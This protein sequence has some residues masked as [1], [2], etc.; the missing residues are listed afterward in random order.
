MTLSEERNDRQTQISYIGLNECVR[1][2]KN[3]MEYRKR[4][5]EEFRVQSKNINSNHAMVAVHMLIYRPIQYSNSSAQTR[6]RKR[7]A[8]FSLISIRI[9]SPFHDDDHLH[10]LRRRT[11]HPSIHRETKEWPINFQS[12]DSVLLSLLLN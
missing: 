6:S 4:E 3:G 7:R 1:E 2:A 8:H 9:C 12:L 10:L 5:R 11:S